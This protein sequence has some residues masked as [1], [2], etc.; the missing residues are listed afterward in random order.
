[1][2][3]NFIQ[4]LVDGDF[5]KASQDFDNEM[6]I[7]INTQVLEIVYGETLSKIGDLSDLGQI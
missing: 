3:E 5:I 7:N 4:S 2:A 1:M 6:K